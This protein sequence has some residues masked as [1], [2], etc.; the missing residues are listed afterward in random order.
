M[1]FTGD[2]FMGAIALQTGLMGVRWAVTNA[3][4]VADRFPSPG[5]EELCRFWIQLNPLRNM[6]VH[7]DERMASVDFGKL[8][9]SG[10]G[11]LISGGI[12][13]PFAQWRGWLDILEPWV[14]QEMLLPAASGDA[15]AR[16]PDWV[17]PASKPTTDE[18]D[19]PTP[20]AIWFGRSL[21]APLARVLA[22]F[23]VAPIA[24]QARLRQGT[25]GPIRM[26]VTG[27][28][29][30]VCLDRTQDLP[31]ATDLVST[32]LTGMAVPGLYSVVLSDASQETM[33]EG[34]FVLMPEPQ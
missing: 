34:S 13:L 8:T 10:D 3:P 14:G 22:A 20:G 25:S 15:L 12:A 33:A 9:V 29:P 28:G 18:T 23:P 27:P 17:D 16:K 4:T 1:A 31:P 7:L 11:I 21:D 24:F 19:L 5:Y 26:I 32:T 6:L 30:Q 2:A